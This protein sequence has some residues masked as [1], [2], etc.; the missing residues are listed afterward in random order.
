MPKLN[1][2]PITHDVSNFV[3]GKSEINIDVFFHPHKYTVKLAIERLVA[4]TKVSRKGVEIY[5]QK[6]AENQSINPI[7]VVKHPSKALYAVLDGHHRYY[8][9]LEMGKKDI[10][11]AI[12][13]DYSS[14]IFYLTEHGW[15]QPIPEITDN[16]RQPAFKL[17]K[18]L[19][20]FL[21]KFVNSLQ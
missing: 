3:K 4:D 9:Y 14:V 15:F 19:K 20:Q 8:A 17:H 16:I 5:K 21:S 7:I 10:D 2:T 13:G 11:C 18:N 12:A 1:L 6:I